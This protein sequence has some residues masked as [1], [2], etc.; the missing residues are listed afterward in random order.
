MKKKLTL[1]SLR[2]DT[3]DFSQHNR[4]NININ[5]GNIKALRIALGICFV[6]F[7][8]TIM[9]VRIDIDKNNNTLKDYTEE[10]IEYK[11]I[12]E[13]RYGARFCL[14]SVFGEGQWIYN[15]DYI[16]SD[17]ATTNEQLLQMREC[18]K[19]IGY[20]PFEKPLYDVEVC[21]KY[22]LVKTVMEK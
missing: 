1:K 12:S 2:N 13:V 3:Y 5:S 15:G 11:N 20:E 18:Y 14:D 22:Q 10:C 9:L 19:E 8:F 16:H 21:S 7:L 17:V 6:L 4:G